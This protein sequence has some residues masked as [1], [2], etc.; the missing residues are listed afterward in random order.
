MLTRLRVLCSGVLVFSEDSMHGKIV[1][2]CAL[3]MAML[4]LAPA[5]AQYPG[6]GQGEAPPPV[7][8][9]PSEPAQAEEMYQAPGLS[10][11]ITYHK[12]NGCDGPVGNGRP[13]ATELF[14]RSGF[15]VPTDTTNFGRVLGLGWDIE[16]G[17]RLL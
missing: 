3:L 9:K 12:D 6:P 8:V 2:S 5:R 14:L 7:K 1:F 13:L 16:G 15:A 4:I 17:G 11:W 10:S